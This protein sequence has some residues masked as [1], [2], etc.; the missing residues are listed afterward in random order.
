LGKLVGFYFF[1]PLEPEDW[2]HKK[3][4]Q[5]TLDNGIWNLEFL[6][7]HPEIAG[8]VEQFQKG[9]LCSR[10]KT[11]DNLAL[12]HGQISQ[13]LTQSGYTCFSKP[14]AVNP[15]AHPLKFL[16]K[17]GT[18]SSNPHEQGVA[19]QEVCIEK[20]EG[21]VVRL[22]ID[23]FP[24]S[25]RPQPHSTKAVVLDAQGDLRSYANEAFKVTNR[26]FPVPKGPASRFG[27]APC[28]Y[29]DKNRCA[30]W[31]DAIMAA[32]HPDLKDPAPLGTR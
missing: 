32:A 24:G 23:G 17:D 8:K 20:K 28:P 29:P 25:K 1:P 19:W 2:V 9:Q 22:K 26:G 13:T 16:K 12:T 15:N 30:R 4:A 31:V 3:L 14:L 6:S 21:C 10:L 7:Q 27:L 11:L 18:E 5:Q